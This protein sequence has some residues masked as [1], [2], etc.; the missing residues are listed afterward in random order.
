MTL[1][2][3]SGIAIGALV[4]I[5][6]GYSLTAS[7]IPI[8][9]RRRFAWV[10]APGVGLGFCS[11]IFFVF[12]R[13]MFTVEFALLVPICAIWF[14]R[15]PWPN[16][17]R[18]F[19]LS[20]R[21]PAF[22]LIFASALT[23]VAT[24]FL[25]E[26][27]RI[28]HGDVDGWAIWN[29]HARMLHRAGPS[30]KS[31]LPYTFHADYPLLTPAVAAR[32]WRYAGAEVPEA[33]ALL[34]IVLSL[35]GVGILGLTLRELRDTSVAMLFA[36]VLLGTPYYLNLASDQFAD[37]PLSFFILGTIA[38]IV[39]H[40]ERDPADPGLLVLAGFTAG[41]A[42]WTK[43]EGLL[44]VL[45]TSSVLFVVL[46]Q[47]RANFLR[48]FAPFVVG[49]LLPLLVVLFFKLSTAR[50]NDLIESSNYTTL[51]GMLNLDRHITIL[52][53]AAATFWSMGGW[54]ITPIIPLF[55]FV[56]LRGTDSFMVRSRGWLTGALILAI[57]AAGYYFVYLITPL[58]L[59]YHLKSS[60]DR[61]MIHLWPSFLLLL[62]LAARPL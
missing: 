62:G 20:W 57:M 30:W 31:I 54:A 60:L 17:G 24:G 33:G 43:N 53:Y 11:L 23:L 15:Q 26:V 21:P 50:Y 1:L 12:R 41:C 3:F 4:A 25:L 51:H 56:G 48:Q 40:L 61:L 13:P 22:G 5:A 39:L 58:D 49:A 16:V 37:V 2:T 28:P 35:S 36:F 29:T 7:I 14:W 46:L 27:D 32:F 59:Q 45:A 52:K 47:K 38:L 42:A 10:F 55:A 19:D 6:F 34:G 9:F 44:F 18:T 8:Q